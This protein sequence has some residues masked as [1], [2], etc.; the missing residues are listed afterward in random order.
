MRCRWGRNETYVRNPK[1]LPL[2]S[3]FEGGNALW[4]EKGRVKSVLVRN[5]STDPQVVATFSLF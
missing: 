1:L 5:I 4:E 3:S 2:F